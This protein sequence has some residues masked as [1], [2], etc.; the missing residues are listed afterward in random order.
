MTMNVAHQED[1]FASVCDVLREVLHLG[2]ETIT[3]DDELD[4]LEN[5][6]S[7]RLMQTVS[8]LERHFD[9]EF[10]DAAI[11]DARTVA[12]LTELIAAELAAGGGAA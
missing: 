11:R 7:V 9:V 5:A 8:E 1:L 12:D 2:D 10:A 6:D 4:L 3:P